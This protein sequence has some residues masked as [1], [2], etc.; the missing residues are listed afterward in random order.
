M[1][2]RRKDGQRFEVESRPVPII[3]RQR[4]LT[5][6]VMVLHDV[7]ETMAMAERMAHLAQYDPLTDLP[8]RVLLQDAP[9]T[10]WPGPPRRQSLAVMYL[11]LDGF[12]RVND[13]PMGHDAGDQLLVQLPAAWRP[14]VRQS[15]TVC[16][17]GGDE[18]VLLLPGLA[19]LRRSARW[20]AK[21]LA[22]VQQPFVLQGQDCALA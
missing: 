8:N 19:A 22:V 5:G 10:P 9:S 12:K 20:C 1:V 4:Q 13:T 2:L 21:V 11:D 16:R 14:P 15:D 18:F 6:A 7:T 3:D 17:Q